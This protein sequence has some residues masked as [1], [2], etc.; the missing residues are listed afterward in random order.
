MA[1]IGAEIRVGTSGWHYGHW[2]GPFYPENLPKDKWL[3]FFAEH[4]DTVEVNNTFYQLPKPHTFENWYT[5]VGGDFV[6]T[7]KANRVITHIRKLKGTAESLGLF[8]ESACLLG[9]KLGAILYQLPPHLH[10]DLGRLSDFIELLDPSIT[11][12]FEFRHDSW[13]SRDTFDML[14]KYNCAFCVHD[15]VGA[16]TPRVITADVIYI[17]FHGAGG[18]YAGNYTRSQLKNWAMWIN[19]NR[20]D[21]SKVYAYFNN[22]FKGYAVGNA[23]TLKQEL[24]I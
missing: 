19:Q 20:D 15:M 21:V 23:M 5:Q 17:R 24:D 16:P 11:A 2:V 1:D 7:L 13:F 12:V 3:G 22:D 10:K 14:G 9:S 8:I 4:F 18:R 6:F